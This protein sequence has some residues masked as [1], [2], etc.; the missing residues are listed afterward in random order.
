MR[1]ARAVEI[2]LCVGLLVGAT[3]GFMGGVGLVVKK[4]WKFGLTGVMLNSAHGTVPG[5]NTIQ[6]GPK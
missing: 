1:T 6:T 4:P 3:L 5:G 2:G